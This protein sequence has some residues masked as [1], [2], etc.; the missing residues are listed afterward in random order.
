M[1]LAAAEDIL[2]HEGVQA[3]SVRR[4]ARNIGYTHGTL[5]LLFENLDGLLR[6]V[7]G[8]TVSELA[9]CLQHVA[10]TTTPGA[11][12]L[13]ALAAAYVQFA[14]THNARWRL[15]FEHRTA[16]EQPLTDT[17]S[18]Q[19]AGAYAVLNKA[20]SDAGAARGQIE[21]LSAA[22]FAAIHGVTVL[23]LDNKLVDQRG[24]AVDFKPILA[25][26]VQV[27]C[28]ALDRPT[29]QAETPLTKSQAIK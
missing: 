8:R 26:T 11:E 19:I 7:N 9:R 29:G 20:L 10:Q 25:R 15:V 2:T 14:R 23:A 5:Y 4:I 21:E 17:L 16:G 22:L 24:E 18:E 28:A 3:L 6:E 13:Q 27:F 1:S 12:C